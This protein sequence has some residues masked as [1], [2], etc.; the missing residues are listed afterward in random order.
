[1]EGKEEN[2]K[3]KTKTEKGEGKSEIIDEVTGEVVSKK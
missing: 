3:D 2:A 1:M